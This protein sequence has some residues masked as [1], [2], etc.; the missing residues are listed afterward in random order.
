[1]NGWTNDV[2]FSDVDYGFECNLYVSSCLQCE[3]ASKMDSNLIRLK[4]IVNQSL[5]L[6]DVDV[7]RDDCFDSIRL[8][9]LTGDRFPCKNGDSGGD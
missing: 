5:L 2:A 4:N 6:A 3:F 1:M 7:V 8:S 9:S